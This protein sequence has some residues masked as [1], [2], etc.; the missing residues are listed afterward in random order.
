MPLLKHA[1]GYAIHDVRSIG[2]SFGWSSNGDIYVADDANSNSTS[3]TNLGQSYQLPAGQNA[4][5]FLT[6]AR[7]FQAAEIEVFR[8]VFDAPH[9]VV[10]VGNYYQ[11]F[12]KPGHQG[13]KYGQ[14]EDVQKDSASTTAA[15]DA[16]LEVGRIIPEEWRKGVH[17]QVQDSDRFEVD[18][19]C[20]IKRSDG[21]WRFGKILKLGFAEYEVNVSGSLTKAGIPG[22][23]IGKMILV[24]RR[25]ED[26]GRVPHTYGPIMNLCKRTLDSEKEEDAVPSDTSFWV[27]GVRAVFPL[28]LQE[29]PMWPSPMQQQLV[30]SPPGQ[31]ASD[32]SGS[33]R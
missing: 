18:E 31:L 22:D 10:P 4:Q 3:Y 28:D 13:V 21:T 2:P 14:H 12:E 16:P 32:L 30:D 25:K 15:I 6:G 24:G 9:L 29:Q 5:T 26:Y 23:N 19:I 11:I 27:E 33:N 1:N 20:V 7:N 8:V 17:Y